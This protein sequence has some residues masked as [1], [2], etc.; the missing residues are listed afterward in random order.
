MNKESLTNILVSVI[1]LYSFF[2]Q[3]PILKL[4]SFGLSRCLQT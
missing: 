1:T 3:V 4:M 2:C